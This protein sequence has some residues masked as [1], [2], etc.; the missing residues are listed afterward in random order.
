MNS[1]RLRDS[2][3]AW[4]WNAGMDVSLGKSLGWD[5]RCQVNVLTVAIVQG[6]VCGEI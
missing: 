1:E 2:K 4:H 3:L 5:F 6:R